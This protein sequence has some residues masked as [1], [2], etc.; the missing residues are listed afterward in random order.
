MAPMRKS[1]SSS[2]KRFLAVLA[3]IA[4]SLGLSL[5]TGVSAQSVSDIELRDQLIANQENL[6]NSYR[7][8]YNTDTH[9]VPGGCENVEHVT[10]GDPPS[11]PTEADLELRDRLIADQEALLNVYRCQFDV[12]TQLVPGGC[13]E[14]STD[15]NVV[16]WNADFAANWDLMTHL[17]DTCTVAGS[18]KNTSFQCDDPADE[19]E[20]DRIVR[21]VYSCEAPYI[22]DGMSLGIRCK[23]GSKGFFAWG[24]PFNEFRWVTQTPGP[25]LLLAC[26]DRWYSDDD[27][28][29]CYGPDHPSNPW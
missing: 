11:A 4:A 1:T 5:S 24:N 21:D 27:L 2:P 7:C 29:I 19:A 20:I 10:P 14:A 17:S 13:S 18:N 15:E 9:V 28:Q 6:L 26:P 23:S 25:G 16:P 8:L 22:Q 12:D 3:L